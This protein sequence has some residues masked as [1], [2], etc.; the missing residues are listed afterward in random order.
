M[1]PR[2]QKK[3]VALLAIVMIAGM[4]I[5]IILPLTSLMDN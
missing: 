2:I 4:L 3:L 5:S 1:K